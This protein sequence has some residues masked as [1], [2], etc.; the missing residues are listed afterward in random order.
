MALK[1]FSKESQA[2]GY[3]NDGQIL[4]KNQLDFRKMVVC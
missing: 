2:D 4:E 3:F 1:I